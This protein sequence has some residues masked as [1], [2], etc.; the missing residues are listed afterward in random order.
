MNRKLDAP[1]I[2]EDDEAFLMNDLSGVELTR[3]HLDGY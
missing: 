3:A 1:D 2:S